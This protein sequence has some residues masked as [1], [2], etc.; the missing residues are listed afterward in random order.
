M[1]FVLEDLELWDIVE[2]VVPPIPVTAPVLVA[3]YRKWNNKAKRT[4]FDAVRDHIIP[5]LTGKAHAY[6]M[7]ASL[8]KLYESSNENRK[9]V[10]HDR[11]RGIHMLKD[12]SVTSFLSRYT[13]IRDELGAVG[14]VVEP[15]SLVRQALNSF[16]KPWG[17]FVRGIVYREAL[18]AWERMW[19]DFVQEEIRLASEA[20]GQRQQQTGQGEE[21]LALWAKGKKKVGRGGRQGP[22]TGGQPQK[23]GGAESS[24]GQGRDM[25]KV[26]CFVCNKFEHYAGQCSNKKKK[27]GGTTAITEET[28]FQTQFQKECVFHAC[29]SSIEFSPHIWYIDSGASSHMTG[30]REHF[31]D[32]RGVEVRIDI[33]L[34]D[35]R[36]VTVAGIGTVSFR[37]ENFPPISF[38]DVL[39]VPGMKKNLILV[40]TLQ[41][42]GLEVSFR[43][44]EVLIY[45]RGSSIDSEQVIGV[46]EGDL[47]RLLFQ[48]LLALVASS[49][50][51]GQL[52]ELWHRRMAHLHHG[53]LG[54]LGEVVTGVPQINIEHQDVCRGCALGKFAKA[55]FPS[56]DSRSVGILDLVHTDVCGPMSRNSLSGCEY[57][58]TFIDDYS[59]KTWIYFLKAKSEVFAQF[60]EFRAL[61]ENQSRKRIKVLRSNNRGEYSSR[62]FVDFC[63][64]HGIRRQM[65]VPYN[66]QQNG[67]AERKNRA[68][69]DAA[70][71]MMHDQSFP[72]YLWAEACATAVYLQN[73]SPH[74]ILGK[75]TPE[76]AFT[77]R[78]PDVKHIRIFGCSTFSHVPSERRT[79]LDPTAQQGIL[80]GYSEV[81]KAY[82]IYIPPLRK[83]VV[84]RDVRFE[85][86]KAFA[87]SLESRGGVEDDVE[88]PDAVSEG[89]Q[90]QW[91]GTP[92]SGVTGSPCTASGSQ[93][94]HVQSDGA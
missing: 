11:L 18:S 1:I 49:D 5:H 65:I 67:V 9:M 59:R 48:P 36:V 79:K 56:N 38:T 15:N 3:E 22:K 14:E 10:L 46:R 73:R 20:S 72:L 60:Q 62:Q 91:L 66:P 29:C 55:S 71:S 61:V 69:T 87:R 32:L 86:D 81:S 89:A 34:G 31:S 30:V 39:F 45:P 50:S 26:K 78:R 88:F 37:R 83:V 44:T 51:S 42:R 57:Y 63:A 19:D 28:D 13:Q 85:E 41:D 94:E 54:G 24:S 52:C 92:V 16:T 84:S 8:C 80:V 25:S 53:A 68:I 2:A 27:K 12:E 6:E 35:N 33:S 93:S 23:S 4:I 74:R 21:D 40:S 58:L 82:H 77:D 90:P 70:R 17:P 64:Q 43:G 7:W 47:Y 75:M 76:E